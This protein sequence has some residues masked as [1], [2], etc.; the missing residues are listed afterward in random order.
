M[1][2]IYGDQCTPEWDTNRLCSIGGTAINLIAPGGM[3]YTKTLYEFAGEMI[4]GVKAESFKFRH[5]ARGL[6]NESATWAAY[7][8]ET[9]NQVEH[10]S[11]I[12]GTPNKHCSPD[13]L[14]GKDGIG[15]GK[16][17][18]PSIFIEASA[19]G[20]YPI[21]TRRQI[22]WGLFISEREWCDYVQYCPEMMN[23]GATGLLIK[24][25]GRDEKM[26]KELDDAAEKFIGDLYDLVERLKGNQ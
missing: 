17:R 15:E 13:A 8:F 11:L 23:A 2:I 24:R 25:V 12:K 6:E 7:T 22:Q 26:I 21:A 1:E 18:I 5:A 16:T 9:G 14:I 3:G 19:V 10:V 20:Y 4:T